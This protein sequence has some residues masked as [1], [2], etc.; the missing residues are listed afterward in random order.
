MLLLFAQMAA[1]HQW[2][3]LGVGEATLVRVALDNVGAHDLA[4]MHLDTTG[5]AA[6][7]VGPLPGRED[8]VWRIR[9]AKAGRYAMQV[10]IGDSLQSKELVVG[11]SA[12][13]VSPV[14][15]SRDWTA[16]LL[17]PIEAAL[18][19]GSPV[20]RISI[21]YPPLTNW[22]YGADWWI[23]SLL[24]ISMAT[25]YVFRSNFGVTF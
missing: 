17:Y 11:A 9:G 19:K 6:V 2:R 22:F 7:E 24:V 14:R 23:V 1:R 8:V 15:P 21:D 25:G 12:S 10:R 16:Q 13:R 18:P 4:K 5:G 3:P 20:T